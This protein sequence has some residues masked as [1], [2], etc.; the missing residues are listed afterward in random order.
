MAWKGLKGKVELPGI[1]PRAFGLPLSSVI[2]IA[3]M[4]YTQGNRMPMPDCQ[5]EQMQA[6]LFTFNSPM[7]KLGVSP[8]E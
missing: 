6:I 3:M 1:K 4:K 2:L 8:A 5:Y 7:K